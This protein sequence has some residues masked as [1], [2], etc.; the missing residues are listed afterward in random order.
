[1]A[2][3]YINPLIAARKGCKLCI[4]LKHLKLNKRGKQANLLKTQQHVADH[5]LMHNLLIINFI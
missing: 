2:E 4:I 5:L 1:M 3:K